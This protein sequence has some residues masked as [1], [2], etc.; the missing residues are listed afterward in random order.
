M[1]DLSKAIR[2]ERRKSKSGKYT[3][4]VYFHLCSGCGVEIGLMHQT[5]KTHS[6]RCMVCSHKGD[7]LRH[8]YNEM[9]RGC[10]GRGVDVQLTYDDFMEI[11]RSQ[12]CYYCAAHVSI[13]PPRHAPGYRG[14]QLD[15]KDNSIGYTKDNCVTCCWR[16]NQIK[17]NRFTYEEFMLL[18]PMLK[19]I[20]IGRESGRGLVG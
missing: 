4:T 17:G 15:R 9:Y 10:R 2:K 16:C 20:R 19:L 6:G 14:Y 12:S 13:D 5:H 7:I 3:Y 1:L 11:R 18:A 8:S